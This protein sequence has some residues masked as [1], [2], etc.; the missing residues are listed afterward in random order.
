MGPQRNE[1]LPLDVRDVVLAEGLHILH[2]A[3]CE[4]M[5]H[6]HAYSPNFDKRNMP[7]ELT[8]PG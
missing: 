7:V 4:A 6:D 1:Q 5:L 3:L 2:M 8:S